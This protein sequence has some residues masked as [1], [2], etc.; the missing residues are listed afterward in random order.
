M[1]LELHGATQQTERSKLWEK[2]KK[3]EQR[4]THAS[5]DHEQLCVRFVVSNQSH[6]H[7]NNKSMSASRSR[8]RSRSRARTPK[9]TAADERRPKDLLDWSEE[10]VLA[11]LDDVG[12]FVELMGGGLCVCVCAW[13]RCCSHNEHFRFRVFLSFFNCFWKRRPQARQRTCARRS[14]RSASTVLH[15]RASYV[16]WPFPLALAAHHPSHCSAART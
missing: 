4:A 14:S 5:L 8:S 11:W 7:H 9:P 6:S 15:S 12:A 13:W 2:K 1:S 10:D 3:L 16:L